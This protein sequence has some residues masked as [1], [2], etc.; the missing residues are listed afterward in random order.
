[1]PAG[2]QILAGS[3]TSTSPGCRVDNLSG[4]DFVTVSVKLQQGGQS[5][6]MT[7]TA[8]ILQVCGDVYC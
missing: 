5:K 8:I 7:A 6:T 2:Y 1:M 3:C 4:D